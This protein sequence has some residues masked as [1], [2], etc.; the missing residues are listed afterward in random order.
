MSHPDP[1]SSHVLDTSS[2]FPAKDI[3]ITMSKW[4]Q[5]EQS[6]IQINKKYITGVQMKLQ[7]Y[8][9]VLNVYYLQCHRSYTICVQV[10]FRLKIV[11]DFL[12]E[13]VDEGVI[14]AN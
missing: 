13:M 2:G 7:I 12:W 4:S 1:V 14:S 6:W 9:F 5:E 10:P 11:I 3:D 8:P